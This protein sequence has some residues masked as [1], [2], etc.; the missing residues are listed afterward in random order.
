MLYAIPAHHALEAFTF[1]EEIIIIIKTSFTL[2][3]VA[4]C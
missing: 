1:T 2:T 4:A 3:Q